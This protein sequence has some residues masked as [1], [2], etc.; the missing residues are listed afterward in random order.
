LLAT[1]RCVNRAWRHLRLEPTATTNQPSKDAPVPAEMFQNGP[2]LCE[3]APAFAERKNP[4]DFEPKIPDLGKP[5]I[6]LPWTEAELCGLKFPAGKTVFVSEIQ[7]G[8]PWEGIYEFWD[9]Q[10][11]HIRTVLRCIAA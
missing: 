5:I 1:V 2:R 6:D 3:A 10:R 4:A 8:V 7:G 9:P 11:V